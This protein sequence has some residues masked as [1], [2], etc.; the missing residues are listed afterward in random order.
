MG[1]LIKMTPELDLSFDVVVIGAGIAGLSVA[2]SLPPTLRI[3]II[4]RSFTVTS[5]HWAKGGVAAACKH[6]DEPAE[7]LRDTIEAGG[8]LNDPDQ[9]ALLVGAA[10]EAIDFLQRQGVDFEVKPEREAGHSQPR[11]WHADGDATGGA[12]MRALS[13]RQR[14]APNLTEIEG[15]L[16]EILNDDNGVVGIMIAHRG[17]L[18]LVRSP[19]VVLASGGATGL[20]SDHTS[21]NSNLGNGIVNAYRVG[22]SVADLEFTQFHPTAIALSTSPLSLATEA[23]RG[24]GAWI[25]DDEG[26]RFLF[27]ADPAGEL[28]TR[29]KVA[30]IMYRHP[31]QAYLDPRPIGRE[32][33]ERRFPTFVQ[34]C[35]QRG[36]DPV[37]HGPVPIRPA[38]HYTIGGVL[39]GSYG[40]TSVPGL[41]AIGE[42]ASTGVHGANR[43]ASNSLLEGVVFG[44]RAADHLVDVSRTLHGV[45]YPGSVDLPTRAPTRASLTHL[46][47]GALGIERNASAISSATERLVNASSTVEMGPCNAW[48]LTLASELISM[49]L[50][51]ARE[52]SGTVGSHTRS[53]E[54]PEDPNYRL[55]FVKGSTLRR[56]VRPK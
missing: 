44:R 32:N 3:A 6:G 36:H 5:S 39:T 9:V 40:E 26:K 37:L 45:Y 38:A 15:S 46:V 52:R 31:G 27:E 4:S 33:L 22:A 48:E 2:L 10:P 16:I 34:D 7:H 56:E 41:Y 24:A 11:I 43:L 35:R 55:T 54:R 17:S 19:R 12:I 20:W 42:C 21:P 25:V 23:L 28:A 8:G 49:M 50:I 47:D 30:R 1:A 14:E 53:D 29:D 18:V 51:A 13:T